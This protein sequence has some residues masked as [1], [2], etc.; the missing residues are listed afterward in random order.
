MRAFWISYPVF[1]LKVGYAVRTVSAA[2]GTHS[3]PYEA[4]HKRLPILLGSVLRK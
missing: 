3:V 2:K 4:V 1:R